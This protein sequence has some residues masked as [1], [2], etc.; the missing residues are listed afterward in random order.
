MGKIVIE[1]VNISLGKCGQFS[2][3]ETDWPR[4]NFID[5]VEVDNDGRVTSSFRKSQGDDLSN[6]LQWRINSQKV[7]ENMRMF[8]SGYLS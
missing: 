5:Y 6:R 4:Y 7:R 2:I 3:P 1:I 8:R